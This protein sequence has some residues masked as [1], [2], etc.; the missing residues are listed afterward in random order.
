MADSGS[1]VLREEAASPL[2]ISKGVQ[3][4]PAGFEVEPGRSTIFLYFDVS[5]QLFLPRY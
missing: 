1:G 3:G 4:F 2:P 5:R